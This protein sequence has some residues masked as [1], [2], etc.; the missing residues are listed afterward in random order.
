MSQQADYRTKTQI[1]L[2]EMRARIISGELAP[3]KRLVIRA[4]ANEFECS[5]I[6][7]RE[8]LRTLASEGLVTIVP[9]GGACVSK[10]DGRELIELTEARALL[11]PE[12]TVAAARVMPASARQELRHLLEKMRGAASGGSYGDYGRLNREFH[13]AILKHCPNQM[14][15]QLIEDLRGRAERGRAVHGVFDGHVDTSMAQHEEMVRCII[16]GDEQALRV[17]CVA[18]AAHGL[19][20][21][22]RLVEADTKANLRLAREAV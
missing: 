13:E 20:A 3:G 2:D 16:Q 15:S 7:V 6:P 19:D 1:L 21:V 10:L 22:H 18:H 9:H 4:L 17:V 12:A 5:D 8:A 14:L 11:E